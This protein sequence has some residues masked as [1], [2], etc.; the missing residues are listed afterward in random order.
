[1]TDEQKWMWFR[2]ALQSW[3]WRSPFAYMACAG[4]LS[5]AAAVLLPGGGRPRRDVFGNRLPER[6]WAPPANSAD[7]IRNREIA[8]DRAGALFYGNLTMALLLAG[9]ALIAIGMAPFVMMSG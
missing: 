2:L 9:V 3:S 1:M 7:L 6:E 5:V 8:E 4:A